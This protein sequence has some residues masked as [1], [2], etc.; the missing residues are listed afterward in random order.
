LSSHNIK[1]A[2]KGTGSLMKEK[3]LLSNGMQPKKVIKNKSM[4]QI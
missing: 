2:N 1:S 3:K 4:K